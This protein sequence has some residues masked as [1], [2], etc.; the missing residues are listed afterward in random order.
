MTCTIGFIMIRNVTDS[1]SNELWIHCYHCIR[2]FYPLY[3]IIIID[4]NSNY[5]FI[6]TIHL[7]N[8]TIID[9]SF[10]NKGLFLAYY[11][12]LQYKFFDKAIIIQDSVFMNSFID[13]DINDSYIFLWDFDHKYNNESFE[14]NM[15]MTIYNDS[16]LL[17]I[18]N[19]KLLWK[20]C[21]YSMCIINHDYLTLIHTKYNLH[22]LLDHI[23][24]TRS[25]SA[26]ERIIACMLSSNYPNSSLFGDIFNYIKWNISFQDRFHYEYLPIIKVWD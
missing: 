15:I 2:K 14:K 10:K 3:P 1:N 25:K 16:D 11:Y 17:D 12:Y 18:Y 4:D 13:F 8:T 7:T 22:L 19:Q 24:D 20:G 5:D 23:I 9:S 6:S 26:F 21:F